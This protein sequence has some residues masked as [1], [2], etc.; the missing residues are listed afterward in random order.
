MVCSICFGATSSVR[1]LDAANYYIFLHAFYIFLLIN[2]AYVGEQYLSVFAFG[3][4]S[5][6]LMHR[7]H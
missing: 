5:L 2:Q 6:G 1:F 3:A 7:P 4:A